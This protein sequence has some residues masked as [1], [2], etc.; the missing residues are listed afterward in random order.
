MWNRFNME[1]I[2]D[3]LVINSSNITPDFFDRDII[4]VKDELEGAY[5]MMY[6]DNPRKDFH[7]S[8]FQGWDILNVILA[9]DDVE[10]KKKSINRTDFDSDVLS[11]SLQ[12]V[13]Y[14]IYVFLAEE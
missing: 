6:N 4:M 14:G 1:L 9:N 2:K 5:L 13:L 12:E 11:G 7:L 8:N 10:I 3:G